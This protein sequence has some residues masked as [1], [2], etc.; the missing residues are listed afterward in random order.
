[1]PKKGAD[2]YYHSKVVPGPGAKPVYF[3]AK[4]LREFNSKR[5]EIIE[6][7]R[8]GS[9]G[10][11]MPFVDLIREWWEV[12]K[13]PRIKEPGTMRVYDSLVRLHIIPAFSP[14][15]MA[16]AVSFKDLQTALD[17]MAGM[18]ACRINHVR[19]VLVWICDYGVAEGVLSANLARSLRNPLSADREERL[20]PTADQVRAMLAAA[21]RDPSGLCVQLVYYLGLRA[22]EAAGLQWGDVDFTAARVH[23]RRAAKFA[24]IGS[25][26]RIGDTK[27]KAA[28]RW[29]PLPDEL[30]EILRPLRGLPT[31]PILHQ[32]DGTPVDSG[33]WYRTW[34][35]IA[36]SAGLFTFADPDH[37]HRPGTRP[38][39]RPLV[40]AHQFRHNYATALYSARIDPIYS[41]RWLGHSDYSFTMSTYTAARSLV[42]GDYPLDPN[43]PAILKKVAEKLHLSPVTL[44]AIL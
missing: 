4:T 1:M 29:V 25:E 28:L 42:D 30:S 44:S 2:G 20:P 38:I 14:S 10:R 37:P 8:T 12:V 18:S 19:S 39:G 24:A 35:T 16:R 7:Y 41:M 15:L 32:D 5:Q 43:L 34:Y 17:K 27:T 36:A 6:K 40:T 3:R 26:A 31:L 11:E 21:D 13:K 23:I 9:E 22:G 33:W